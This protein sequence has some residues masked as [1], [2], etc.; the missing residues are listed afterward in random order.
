MAQR[1]AIWQVLL[2][3]RAPPSSSPARARTLWP[4]CS[5]AL[6]LGPDAVTGRLSSLRAAP[7]DVSF[8]DVVP[9]EA[10]TRWARRRP[11]AC[12][13]VRAGRR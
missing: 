8:A 10:V 2:A 13:G 4:F 3:P 5:H 12:R 11:R 1:D 6:A 9:T 7:A